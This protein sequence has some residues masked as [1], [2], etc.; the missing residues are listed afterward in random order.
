MRVI[1]ARGRQNAYSVTES[2]Y[3]AATKACVCLCESV[4]DAGW[5]HREIT[6]PSLR[7]TSRIRC[8]ASPPSRSFLPQQTGET[9]PAVGLT[10]VVPLR[11]DS[12]MILTTHTADPDRNLKLILRAERVQVYI[13]VHISQAV[14]MVHTLHVDDRPR[15][16][17]EDIRS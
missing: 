6:V 3:S 11:Q 16:F 2:Y 10:V 8:H 7:N 17:S 13:A 14:K 12:V 1:G 15:V 9:K 5:P 4:S